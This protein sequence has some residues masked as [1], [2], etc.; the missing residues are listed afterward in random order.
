MNIERVNEAR[1]PNPQ[2]R[3]ET[4][5]SDCDVRLEIPASEVSI[6]QIQYPH[7]NY[8][9]NLTFKCPD[10]DC[11]QIQVKEIVAHIVPGVLALHPSFT[12]LRM[13]QDELA[14]AS[15]PNKPLTQEEI[16]EKVNDARIDLGRLQ[17]INDMRRE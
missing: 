6:V 11:G 4:S 3:I 7:G 17:T 12:I 10:E 15:M 9:F 13:T 1:E 5:C 14:R 2:A 8:R 16:Q